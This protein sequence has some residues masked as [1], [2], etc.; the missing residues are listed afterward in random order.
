[1][2][3][4]QQQPRY[5]DDSAP[6]DDGSFTNLLGFRPIVLY[7]TG[8]DMVDE[9]LTLSRSRKD[10]QLPQLS[11]LSSHEL[12]EIDAECSSCVSLSIHQ[13]TRT[14]SEAAPQIQQYSPPPRSRE[15]GLAVSDAMFNY[16]SLGSLRSG[17]AP[18]SL[19]SRW[20]AGL[21]VTAFAS[22]V[23]VGLVR[24]AYRPLLLSTLNDKFNRKYDADTAL[25]DWP[26]M[27]S[28]FLG[29]F[30]DCVPIYG[31]R[32]K[33]YIALGW[34]F[35]ALSYANVSA[36]Y[37]SQVH[38][39]QEPTPIY[40]HLIQ[41]W[42]VVG[43]FALQLSWVGALASVVGFGQ[44]EALSKRGGLATLFLVIWQG[45]VLAARVVVAQFQPSSS[46]LE[47]PSAILAATSVVALPFV[48]CF[49]HDDDE[50]ESAATL[51][52]STK[53]VGIVP[54]LRT[55]IT[56]LWE[57]CQE[58]V[59]YRVLL[60]L[61][62]YGVLLKAYDPDVF[63]A[64]AIWSGFETPQDSV[65]V[66]VLESGV[67]LAALLHAKWRLL[68]SAWR[69]LAFVG[70]GVA[71]VGSIV[72]AAIITTD[73][74]R[75]QW[76]FSLLTGIVIWSKT[77]LLLFTM[78][79]ITEVAHVGCE[80]VTMGLVLSFQGLGTSAT[81]SI[82]G[83]ISSAT[84]TEVTQELIDDDTHDTRVRIM[85]AAAV[86]AAVNLLS[87]AAVPWLPRSKLEAQQL[88]A[89]G[90]YNRRGAAFLALLFVLLLAL[91]I[92]DSLVA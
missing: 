87:A 71:V 28:V 13:Q 7:D 24:A 4:Q 52:A 57:L 67:T 49:L 85:C 69:Q 72:Q 51:V 16:R 45:G 76:F 12:D 5:G 44:R 39:V 53:R 58:K 74:V 22:G 43:S 19:H 38:D 82:V 11:A 31:T 46:S 27:L 73:T 25:L 15:R 60:F 90:G 55:G 56:H 48:L 2:P 83:W 62:V 92:V 1:M 26:D 88:R 42:S 61:L 34:I 59:T 54:A 21:A 66:L 64:L 68:S 6:V 20:H 70:T 84:R 86:C 40:G 29:L 79:A 18:I 63:K 14:P 35:S 65:H 30:S 37:M 47:A 78:L 41:A 17:L 33:A 9:S 36:L 3:E 89:F 10:L 77:W 23:A 80:G 32:R 75:T 50:Q 81:S 91:A 8:V